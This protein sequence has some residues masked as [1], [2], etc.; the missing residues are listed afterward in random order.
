MEAGKQKSEPSEP[1]DKVTIVRRYTCEI[2]S[3]NG[4]VCQNP[5][6]I[7]V[8]RTL[9]DKEILIRCCLNCEIPPNYEPVKPQICEHRGNCTNPASVVVKTV[10]QDHMARFCSTCAHRENIGAHIPSESQ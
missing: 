5:P 3:S 10:D 7:N 6:F 9:Q 4:E 2:P 8:I 1:Q